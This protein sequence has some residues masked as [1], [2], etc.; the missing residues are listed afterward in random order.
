MDSSPRVFLVG[1]GPGHPGLLTLRAV[2]CLRQADLVLYDKLVPTRM[3]D[4]ARPQAE[5]ICIT[6]LG[7]R[8]CERI[9]PV[10]QMLI[11][12]ARQG[13]CV[14]R[15]KGGDP[16]LFGRGGEEALALHEANIPFEIVPGV[17]A[18]LGAGAF[19]GIP[20]THRGI[21]SAVALVTGH[22]NP[23]KGEPALDWQALSRFPGTLV[24][25]MGFA[26]LAA[27]ARTLIDNGKPANTPAAVIQLATTGAQQTVVASLSEIAAKVATL[28]SP[29]LCII[30]PVVALRE[31]LTWFEKRPLLGRRILVCRP[32]HQ[33]QELVERLEQLGAVPLVM[34]VVEIR[35]PN[36]WE[37]ADAAICRLSHFDWLVFTSANG[38]HGFLSRLRDLR[39]LGRI[40]LAAI[41]PA[42]A[43]AL[44]GYHL[45]PD[46]I[47]DDYRSESLAT[48]L[49]PHVAG[50][51]VLLARADR[52]RELL[53]EE[54]QAIAEV[55]QVTVY[56]QVDIDTADPEIVDQLRIGEIDD[57]I[58][59][60]SNIARSLARLLDEPCH[61]LLRSGRPRIVSISPVTSTAI[62]ELGWPVAMEAKEH[63]M[64]GIVKALTEPAA[65]A[66]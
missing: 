33:A 20:L 52:G 42:T 18:A 1:A 22:E 66:R 15:L 64:E 53:Q 9:A 30:G 25:Y 24:V 5:R 21:A 55:Q 6:E 19:A 44:R 28:A 62:R 38:V 32:R 43:A 8:H 47:P 17:T 27:I 23:E 51:R 58:L 65:Q 34:P 46:L 36:D 39:E 63:T 12:A 4:H 14:V 7:P 35:P 10:S 61:A 13:K 45:Q 49:R 40:R 37:A 26:R 59:T 54:L 2:E 29:A 3:L 11:D 57:V 31:Q 60:S 48:A 41:G 50:K 16:L 56:S